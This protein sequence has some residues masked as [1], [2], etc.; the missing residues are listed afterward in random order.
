MKKRIIRVFLL[1]LA[2][3]GYLQAQDPFWSSQMMQVAEPR[4]SRGWIYLKKDKTISTDEFIRSYGALIGLT[5][6]STLHLQRSNTDETGILHRH[7]E[8]QLFGVPVIGTRV[9]FHERDGKLIIVN[10]EAATPAPAGMSKKDPAHLTDILRNSVLKTPVESIGEAEEVYL[11]ERKSDRSMEA[12]HC[13][14]FLVRADQVRVSYYYLDAH[15]GEFAGKR[16][17]YM[18]CTTHTANTST[19]GAQTIYTKWQSGSTYILHDDCGSEQI[20]VYNQLNDTLPSTSSEYSYAGGAT[21]PSSQSSG[22]QTLYCMKKTSQY[23]NTVHS[24]ISW[25]NLTRTDVVYSNCK[26]K[27]ASN[28][29]YTRNAFYSNDTLYFGAATAGS[30]SDMAVLDVTAHEYTHGVTRYASFLQYWKEMGAINESFSDIFG[31]IVEYYV[32]GNC[33]WQ[34]GTETGMS[35]RSMSN[36]YIYGQPS[37]YEGPYWHSVNGTTAQDSADN[38]GVHTNSGVQNF[39]FYLLVNGGTDTN[40]VGNLVTVQPIGMTAARAIAYYALENF[41]GPNT[42]YPD[43]RKAWLNASDLLYGWCSFEHQQLA[44]AWDAVGVIDND[45]GA[46]AA[47]G[48][49]PYMNG[50]SIVNAVTAQ[51]Y[52]IAGA[53]GCSNTIVNTAPV[54]YTATQFITLLPGF[55]ADC[56]LYFFRTTG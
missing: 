56:R 24:R 47:C 27:S 55:H 21:W 1:L 2:V 42:D 46:L 7:Y 33:N 52:I 50:S 8:Q 49:F 5:Q 18:D 23:Y 25:S 48:T 3:T 17:Q 41:V 6:N 26:L 20:H 53:F 15:T 14:R 54:S 31:E 11:A 12:R 51:S 32:K 9:S 36:P 4:S 45:L 38:F 39:M 35:F 28:V 29:W 22:T 19:Y 10:G 43:A 16:D 34:C 44:L 37:F 30:N 40:I 13:Y